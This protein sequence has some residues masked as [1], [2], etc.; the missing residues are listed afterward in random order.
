MKHY[1]CKDEHINF[2]CKIFETP[3]NCKELIIALIKNSEINFN[4]KSIKGD[5]ISYNFKGKDFRGRISLNG[6]R[7]VLE[8]IEFYVD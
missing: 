3:C 1:M 8:N 7:V 5:T 2:F 4:E 6:D